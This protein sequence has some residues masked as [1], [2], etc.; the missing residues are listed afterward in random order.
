MI[1]RFQRFFRPAPWQKL[2]HNLIPTY[3][4]LCSRRLGERLLCD[5]CEMDLPWINSP[6]ACQQ[7]AIPLTTNSRFCG[8]CLHRP[9]A[10]QRAFIP[11]LY[12]HPLDYLISSFKYR[13]NLTSGKALASLLIPFMQNAYEE[14]G[15]E[16]PS[17][18]LPVPLHWRRRLVRGFNQSSVLAGALAKG[19]QIKS[20]DNGCKRQRS[21]PSQKGLD[22]QQRQKNLRGVF[23]L[24]PTS[25]TAIE[26]Q[27]VAILDDVVTTTAT[28]RELAQLLLKN[29]AREVHLWALARTPERR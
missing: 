28:A 16:W 6:N 18:I 3:C 14:S 22:R 26:G 7:C 9:P 13:R 8:H 29:G 4:L 12:D 20:L 21:T 27:C 11:F 23:R 24:T 2:L 15:C 5:D 1:E 19:L 17:L 10:F 25:C